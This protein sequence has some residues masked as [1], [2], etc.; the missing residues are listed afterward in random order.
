MQKKPNIFQRKTVPLWIQISILATFVVLIIWSIFLIREKLLKNANEMGMHLAES[1]AIEE[2]NRLNVY[3]MLLSLGACYINE[4]IDGDLPLDTSQKW[5]YQYTGY[6]SDLLGASI[7]DPYAVI[8]GSIVAAVPLE[9][10]EDYEYRSTEWYQKALA[11]DGEVIYTDAYK[12]AITG[13]PMVTLACALE[14]E[15]NVLAFDILLKNFH[16][17][18]NRS[19]MPEQSSYFL[20]DS[21][22]NLMYFSSSMDVDI[23]TGQAYLDSLIDSVRTGEMEKYDSTITDL[24]GKQRGVY[25]YEASNGWLSV[26]TIPIDKILQDGW[27]RT[28]II[29][30]VIC[31]ILLLIAGLI[32]IKGHMSG[33]KIRHISDT[34]QLLGDSYYAIY[35]VNFRQGTYESIKSSDDITNILG[36]SGDYEHLINTVKQV[37][38]H[39]TYEDFE[40]SF[41]LENIRKLIASGTYNFGGD[42]KRKFRDEYKWVSIQ[43]VYNKNMHLDEVIMCFRDINAQKHKELQQLILLE[44]A[45]SSAKKTVQQKNLFFSNASHDMR[46]PLNAIIGFAELA[47]KNTDSHLQ[48]TDYLQKIEHSGRQLLTLVNDVLDMS[49]LE[50]EKGNTLEYSPMDICKCVQDT[51]SLF[52]EQAAQE[53][54]TLEL[55]FDVQNP[56]VFCDPA[57]LTQILNNL[58]SNAFK[59]SE[60][61]AHVKISLIERNVQYGHGKFQIIVSDTGIGMSAEF[62]QHIFEPFARETRFTSGNITG[63]GLGMPIVKTLVQQMSGEITV[64]SELGT[65]TEFTITFPLQ[66]AQELEKP[67]ADSS[68]QPSY[69]LDG[70]RILIA[71]DNELNMEIATEYLTMLGAD[72]LPAWNGQEAV[73]IFQTQP[74][75]SIDAILMDMQMPVMDGCEAAA[76][77]RALPHKDAATIPI[78]AVTA[79]VFAEDIARTTEA[80]MDAHIPKP[81]DIQQLLQVLN[82]CEHKK[83]KKEPIS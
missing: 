2:E 13:E 22:G 36:A 34:L 32:M 77:I 56:N 35:R 6:L 51:A 60:K 29:L 21:S 7:V 44:N 59:Y 45:L 24:G 81:I 33:K 73:T 70:K 62:L 55:C 43:I 16:T 47:Q 65:G 83:K 10:V 12:D 64:R 25:Y 5:M 52:R 26:I 1:Y 67:A 31:G 79:N 39:N 20:F 18:E 40:Q 41:S 58:L 3:S 61:G 28:I 75:F 57:R 38:D 17:H 19:S 74:E 82:D 72:V 15:G 63:T 14:G 4:N 78:I 66:L 49:R 54:K 23:E 46:T 9:G 27:D 53:E 69:S 8:N 50:H 71:E 48:M 30:S 42:Y 76:A 37:V 68:V 11:A 80:G